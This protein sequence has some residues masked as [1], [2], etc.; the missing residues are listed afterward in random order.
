MFNWCQTVNIYNIENH[1]YYNQEKEPSSAQLFKITPGRLR[2]GRISITTQESSKKSSKSSARKG[3]TLSK[4]LELTVGLDIKSMI[5][6]NTGSQFTE[7]QHS[8]YSEHPTSIS[9]TVPGLDKLK[10]AENEQTASKMQRDQRSGSTDTLKQSKEHSQKIDNKIKPQ[11]KTYRSK[12]ISLLNNI[13][14]NGSVT[15]SNRSKN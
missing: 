10:T 1:Y 9:S 5:L 2:P 12:N 7:K 15:S 6:Q 3:I 14:Q 8:V 13:Y 11:M 4:G